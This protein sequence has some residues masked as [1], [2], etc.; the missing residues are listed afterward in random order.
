MKLKRRAIKQSIF[1]VKKTIHKTEMIVTTNVLTK[2]VR[3]SDRADSTY[4]F[5]VF[6]VI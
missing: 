6:N 4:L 2:T 1:Q 3:T 5:N